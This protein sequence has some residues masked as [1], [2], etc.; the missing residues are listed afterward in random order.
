MNQPVCDVIER[1]DNG[2]VIQ[3]G[4]YNDRIY[5]MK[6]G[7][8][9]STDFAG[10][11]IKQAKQENYSKI[12][13]KVPKSKT[14]MFISAGLIAEAQVPDFY[15][16]KEDVIFMSYFLSRQRTIEKNRD[17]LDGIVELARSKEVVSDF[18]KMDEHF[19][20]RKC[21]QDDVER[22]AELYKTVFPSYP[23]PIDDPKYLIDTMES[24]VMYF[25]IENEGEMVALSSAEMDKK[26]L[27]VEMTD[28]ATLPEMRGHGFALRLL[29][30]MEPEVRKLN[31][32]TAYTIARSVSPGMNITFAKAGYK[33]GG[34]LVNNT[35]ISGNIESMNIWYKTL[36]SIN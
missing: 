2:S 18:S 19:S 10:Q 17:E 27:N 35:N 3:H 21:T 11:L 30:H 15:M 22:M 23:F 26:S 29:Y 6:L 33:F 28:F 32:K 25:C 31:I 1:I 20:L 5:L 9:V 34:R 13:A 4:Y 36:E 24:H 16:G 12:F 7:K 14:D 8:R